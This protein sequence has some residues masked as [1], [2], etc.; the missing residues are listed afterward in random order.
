MMGRQD[1]QMTIVLADIRQ[2]TQESFVD[3]EAF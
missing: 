3:S 2:K 1:R